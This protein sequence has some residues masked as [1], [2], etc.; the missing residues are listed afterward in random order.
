MTKEQAEAYVKLAKEESKR[1]ME[2][3][4]AQVLSTR[5][6]WMEELKTDK[7][8]GGEFFDKNVDRVEKLLDKHMPNMKKVLTDRGTMLPPYIMK[9]LLGVSKLL[10][11]TTILVNGESSNE[12]EPE[13]NFLVDLYK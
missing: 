10:N 2:D 9:D 3:R 5:K 12:K 11:P 7:S 4:E 6:Q 8:F 13:T 1:L